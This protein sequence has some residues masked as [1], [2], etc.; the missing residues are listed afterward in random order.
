MDSLLRN[1]TI[2]LF[3]SATK[4]FEAANVGLATKTNETSHS[5]KSFEER[6]LPTKLNFCNFLVP[7]LLAAA[8]EKGKSKNLFV[9][10]ARDTINQ[11]QNSKYLLGS[12]KISIKECSLLYLKIFLS[13][14]YVKGCDLENEITQNQD[15]L[16]QRKVTVSLLWGKSIL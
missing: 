8:D 14:R 10:S 7:R 9:L 6:I 2:F 16:D 5:L 4:K 12:M 13:Y 1:G 3:L 11:S 15:R